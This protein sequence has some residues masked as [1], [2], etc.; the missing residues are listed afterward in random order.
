MKCRV[1][2]ENKF[3]ESIERFLGAGYNCFL[4]DVF[5]IFPGIE[6]AIS[7]GHVSQGFL[8]AVF[9]DYKIYRIKIYCSSSDPF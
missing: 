5:H 1:F 4:L 3:T 6:A 9:A 7:A 8:A 2:L